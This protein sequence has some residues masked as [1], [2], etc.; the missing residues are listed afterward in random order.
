VMRL[1][2][3]HPVLSVAASPPFTITRIFDGHGSCHSELLWFG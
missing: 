3:H 2:A 1:S